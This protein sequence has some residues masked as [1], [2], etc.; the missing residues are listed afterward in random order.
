MRKTKKK[1]NCLLGSA[2]P[3]L[4]MWSWPPYPLSFRDNFFLLVLVII[5]V[6]DKNFSVILIDYLIRFNITVSVIMNVWYQSLVILSLL[7]NI[8]IP[9]FHISFRL[10]G[11]VLCWVKECVVLWKKAFLRPKKWRIQYYEEETVSFW[12]NFFFTCAP[13]Y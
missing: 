11:C 8:L 12:T 4:R 2:C 10:F 1:Q 6:I 13:I 9:K 5:K 7:T 3:V